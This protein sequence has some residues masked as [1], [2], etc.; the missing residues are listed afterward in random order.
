MNNSSILIFIISS[1][2]INNELKKDQKDFKILLSRMKSYKVEINL[3]LK[4]IIIYIESSNHI[5]FKL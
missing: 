1:N 2:T 5:R 3:L 4:N